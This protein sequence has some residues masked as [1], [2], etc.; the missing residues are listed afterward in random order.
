M[1]LELKTASP[2]S[3]FGWAGI[4]VAT[5][6]LAPRE[7]IAVTP[8]GARGEPVV[9][10]S[11]TGGPWRKEVIDAVFQDL[12][13]GLANRHIQTCPSDQV[14]GKAPDATIRL[15][16][17][18]FDAV[19]VTVEIHDQVTEKVV[20]RDVDLSRVPSD[21]QAFAIALA[22][23][24]LVWASWA[25]IAIQGNPHKTKAPAQLVAEVHRRIEPTAPLPRR[26]GMQAATEHYLRGHTQFGPDI[27]LAFN[28]A[29]RF[30]LRFA[31]GYR[32]GLE[33]A[34]PDGSIDSSAVAINVDLSASVLRSNRLELMW[35]VG[36]RSAWCH[37]SG[38]AGPGAQ[39]A[40]LN[41][42]TLY[43]RT[44]V[45][46]V[47]RPGGH[48]WL[49]LGAFA[50]VPLRELEAT[51]TTRVVTGVSGLEQSA[52]IAVTAEL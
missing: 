32:Q 17:S 8:C 34:A 10:V 26:L 25:E 50:G 36:E 45:L 37:F 28:W 22:A 6:L 47:I 44:G 12:R 2:H 49:E 13:A 51:D 21:G 31:G 16:T 52:L 11:F 38:R 35:T 19:H 40:E 24:E 48:L 1:G 14:P 9:N 4:M 43:A 18:G 39:N 46:A 7:G 20:S 41:G 5:M 29:P 33:V 3:P 27:V 30:G 42:L 23:D 15:S